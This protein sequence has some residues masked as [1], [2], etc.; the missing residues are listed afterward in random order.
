M[1]SRKHFA[2][3]EMFAGICFSQTPPAQV[4]TRVGER[5]D[6]NHPEIVGGDAYETSD[7]YELLDKDWNPWTL[8]Y[9]PCPDKTKTDP[10][11]GLMFGEA[12]FLNG[13]HRDH[14][15]FPQADGVYEIGIFQA[16]ASPKNFWDVI[17]VNAGCAPGTATSEKTLQG[18]LGSKPKVE[19]YRT[20]F[21]YFL[22]RGFAL[23]VR[24]K[25]VYPPTTA[26]AEEKKLLDRWDYFVNTQKNG[27]AKAPH[28]LLG[29]LPVV[30]VQPLRF[31]WYDQKMIS[32]SGIMS[33]ILRFH[34]FMCR[35]CPDGFC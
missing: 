31:G 8:F 23:W 3:H 15:T 2:L 29:D 32:S 33:K 35:R 21:D 24:W 12:A 27:N 17:V 30:P 16:N 20:W 6:R 7:F 5:F 18:R 1:A 10:T 25:V 9:T 26:Q 19:Q 13:R 22:Q 14:A 4:G 34:R 28:L 11:A